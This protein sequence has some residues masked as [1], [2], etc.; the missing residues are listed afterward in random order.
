L[1][2][3]LYFDNRFTPKYAV[4][5]SMEYAFIVLPKSCMDINLA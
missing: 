2:T 3:L 5:R 1:T 4:E